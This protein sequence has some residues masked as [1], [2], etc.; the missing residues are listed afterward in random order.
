MSVDKLIEKEPSLEFVIPVLKWLK[1]PESVS[2]DELKGSRNA[3]YAATNATNAADAG[4]TAYA[5]AYAYADAAS[6][7]GK[8]IDKYFKITGISRAEVEAKLFKEEE[9]KYD[10]E[11]FNNTK[12]KIE[13]EE[14]N[15]YVQRLAFKAGWFWL[16]DD[17]NQQ[18]VNPDCRYLYFCHSGFIAYHSIIDINEFNSHANKEI[19]ITMP[20]K[21]D[22][23]V[24]DI[25]QNPRHYEL[26]DD[27][28][29][30]EIIASSM[31]T[32]AF[33]GYCLGNVLKY[34]LRAGNKDDAT[35]EIAKADK[36][37]ELYEDFK[38]LCK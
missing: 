12:I 2:Q 36:Y 21:E 37:K 4:N 34:R 27:T 17:N 30:I 38:H 13:S 33:H 25:V 7:T 19:F 6:A 29:V 35:Q 26:F 5:Y 10:K 28:Q 23:P 18:T 8:W 16:F 31:S 32:E 24:N 14:H 11:F 20:A 22:G 1:D 9:M 3:A 15:R